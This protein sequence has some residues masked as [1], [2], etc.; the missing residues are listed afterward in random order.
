MAVAFQNSIPSF[1]KNDPMKMQLFKMILPVLLLWHTALPASDTIPT[2]SCAACKSIHYQKNAV[3]IELAHAGIAGNATIQLTKSL[4]PKKV[5]VRFLDFP[6]I[7]GFEAIADSN[8]QYPFRF[9]SIDL[10]DAQ[11]KDWKRQKKLDIELPEWFVRKAKRGIT[12][13]YIVVFI[14]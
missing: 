14:R 2:V 9:S 10:S 4:W 12:I 8:Y 5:T 3:I 7:E 13:H 6:E 1:L 11:R